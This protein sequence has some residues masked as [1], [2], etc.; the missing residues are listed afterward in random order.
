MKFTKESRSGFGL[1]RNLFGR[2]ASTLRNHGLALDFLT[3]YLGIAL[4]LRTFSRFMQD[5]R[6]SDPPARPAHLGRPPDSPVG[7]RRR[8]SS[9]FARLRCPSLPVLPAFPFSFLLA[10]SFSLFLLLSP[11]SSCS[12]GCA[13][14]TWQERK[15][16]P[17]KGY[18]RRRR[19][20]VSRVW[21]IHAGWHA[22]V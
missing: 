18:D 12:R 20:R 10:F 21:D 22:S 6:F 19:G 1:P 4:S 13:N 9:P 2:R 15:I 17:P 3:I 5:P 7:A 14:Y 16:Y 8:P 11:S